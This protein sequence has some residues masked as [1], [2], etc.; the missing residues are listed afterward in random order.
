MCVSLSEHHGLQVVPF[1]LTPVLAAALGA[2]G[3]EGTFRAAAEA[4]LG[5][6]RQ[7]SGHL[8]ALLAA[9]LRDPSLDWASGQH[10]SAARKVQAVAFLFQLLSA[11]E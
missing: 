5:A 8:S 6:L 2:T 9:N 11:E 3:V 1:R 10:D 7:R 4:T